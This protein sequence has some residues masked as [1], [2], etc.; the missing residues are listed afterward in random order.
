MNRSLERKVFAGFVLALLFL[1]VIGVISYRSLTRL[2]A[3]AAWVEHTQEVLACLASLLS[4]MTDAET[5]HRGC[6]VTDDEK[7]LEPRHA[8]WLA[9]AVEFRRG[10][11]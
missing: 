7:F 6:A 2:R 3:D 8:G 11:S 4:T 5:V 10:A 1:G 9:G